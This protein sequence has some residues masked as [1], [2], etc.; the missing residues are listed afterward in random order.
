MG[1]RLDINPQTLYYSND[2]DQHNG[3][4]YHLWSSFNHYLASTRVVYRMMN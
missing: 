3:K 2:S 1:E 4:I